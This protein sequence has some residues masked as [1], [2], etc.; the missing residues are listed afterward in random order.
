MTIHKAQAATYDRCFVLAGDQ[1]TKE[2]AYTALSRARH[3]TDLYIVSEDPRAGEVHA[4]L[5]RPEPI[6]RLRRSVQRSTAQKMA[7]DL[8]ASVDDG[9][10]AEL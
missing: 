6:D 9:A 10:G 5:H 3:G 1:L 2:S 4:D 8:E 7:T